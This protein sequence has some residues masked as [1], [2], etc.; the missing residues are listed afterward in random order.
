MYIIIKNSIFAVH[1]TLVHVCRVYS[2]EHCTKFETVRYS[3]VFLFGQDST[4]SVYNSTVRFQV[5]S[6]LYRVL[7]KRFFCR[8]HAVFL[9]L[10]VYSPNSCLVLW[11]KIGTFEQN[12]YF[13]FFFQNNFRKEGKLVKTNLR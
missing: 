1:V 8:S 5:Y 12:E 6:S 13:F 4:N 10:G 11:D 2:E 3:L 9:D 7:K